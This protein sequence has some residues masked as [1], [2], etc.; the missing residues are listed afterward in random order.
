MTRQT[1]QFA[2]AADGVRL[3]YG[4]SGS[5]PMLV[6]CANWLNH[7]EFDWQ[8][9]VWK[10]WFEFL[11]EHFTLLRYDER[12]CGLSDRNC[13]DLS[14]EAW[15]ND[16]ETVV[17]ANGIETFP[18]LG[19]SQGA[20]VA[21]EYC[22]RHPERVSHLI[23]FGGYARG[24]GHRNSDAEIKHQQVL[25]TLIEAGWEEDNPAFRQVF[26]SFFVPGGGSEH[27]EW[28][29]ELCRKTANASDALKI[30]RGFSEIDVSARL[31]QLDVPTLVVHSRD[32]A[33]C[34]QLEG[35]LLATEIPGAQFVELESENHLLLA[36]EPAWQQFC[37]AVCH[38]L[39]VETA[40]VPLNGQ[41]VLQDL[42]EKERRVLGLLGNG[43][44]NKKIA[45]SLFLSEKTIRNHLSRIYEK[46]D[47][48]SR[49]EAIVLVRS[50]GQ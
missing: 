39:Q 3:A 50:L 33:V 4:L 46:L 2:K 9:P 47:V 44:S 12:G 18:L 38:F 6:K 35:R 22:S 25:E 10:H 28:F 19:I 29:A 41:M 48:S 16:L 8:S 45:E 32:D 5:G 24:S 21:I 37:D 17:D 14:F 30:I 26:S 42:T 49:G 31:A 36:D 34:P 27:S 7:L 40:G 43:L 11:S 15:V 23:L 1:I 13:E 20:S